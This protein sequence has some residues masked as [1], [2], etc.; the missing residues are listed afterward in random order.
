MPSAGAARRRSTLATDVMN[1]S[2]LI[3]VRPRIASDSRLAAFH[4]RRDDE[5]LD[6]PYPLVKAIAE[7]L[8][9]TFRQQEVILKNYDTGEAEHIRQEPIRLG[10]AVDG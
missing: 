6:A 9:R 10:S 5:I 3:R 8:R 1:S 4:D 7:Q 2:F